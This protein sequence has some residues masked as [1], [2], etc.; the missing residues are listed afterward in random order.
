MDKVKSIDEKG[1]ILVFLYF[2]SNIIL[3]WLP[4]CLFL[5]GKIGFTDF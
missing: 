3:S 5:Q 2:A 4:I 1:G